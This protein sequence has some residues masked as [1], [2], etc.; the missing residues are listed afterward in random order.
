MKSMSMCKYLLEL[1]MISGM[2]KKYD[3]TMLVLG[4]ITISDSIFKLK[5]DVKVLED[6]QKPEKET[7]MKCF[8]EMCDI[9][10]EC[11]KHKKFNAVIK[12]Y[13]KDKYSKVAKIKISQK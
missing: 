2:N 7:L 4:S 3:Q 1:G 10:K 9:L 8:K 11:H 12:K 6:G 5:S 13:Q